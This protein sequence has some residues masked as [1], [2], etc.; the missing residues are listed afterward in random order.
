MAMQCVALHQWRESTPWASDKI[1]V[2]GLKIDANVGFDAWGR[3]GIQPVEINVEIGLQNT[4]SSAA[5]S[6]ALDE[7]TVH[8]GNL[9][10][11]IR[12]R[13]P[14]DGEQWQLPDAFAH[15]MMEV[16]RDAASKSA[17]ISFIEMSIAFPEASLYGQDSCLSVSL[18]H[19][20]ELS[21]VTFSLHRLQM[22]AL[23]GV[24]ARERV[25]KQM[26]IVDL[27]IDRLKPHVSNE[28]YR[29]EQ[30]VVKTVEESAFETL[31]SL[32][33]SVTSK[34]IKYF[35]IANQPLKPNFEAEPAGVG[36]KIAKPSAVPRADAAAV[37]IY[38]SAQPDNAYGKRLY[39]EL[40][41]KRPK[42]PYPLEGRL[43]E[44]LQ[45]WK[46]D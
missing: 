8:Y 40:G 9:S 15:Q 11:I 20:L 25:R 6:D 18:N 28:C 23:I 32:C 21:S 33:E 2:S 5:A 1:R 26:I 29:V 31:E 10:K 3:P 14:Q 27:F 34:V 38:R 30:L 12:S 35:V 13:V 24:N 46:Q 43:D 45:A 41:N 36:V 4:I 17:K 16:V 22:P 42:V 37:E 44:F 7:S 39:A 19:P